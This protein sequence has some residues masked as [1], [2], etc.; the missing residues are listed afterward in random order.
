M[1]HARFS[2]LHR[3]FKTGQMS[4]RA[5]LSMSAALGAFALTARP[6]TGHAQ[7]VGGELRIGAEFKHIAEDIHAPETTDA[8]SVLGQS[9]ESLAT[10]D[11]ENIVRPRVAESWQATDDLTEWTLHL[12]RNVTWHN[13]DPLTASDVIW[14]MNRAGMEGRAFRGVLDLAEEPEKIDDFTVKLRLNSPALYVPYALTERFLLLVHP[15]YKGGLEGIGT[16]PFVPQEILSD[17]VTLDAFE[18]YR[19]GRPNLDRIEFR[20][21][22]DPETRTAAF[23]ADEIQISTTEPNWEAVQEGYAVWAPTSVTRVARMRVDQTPYDN[24]NVRR[25]LRLAV[26]IAAFNDKTGGGESCGNTPRGQ[27]THKCGN[28]DCSVACCK[29]V[30]TN[31]HISPIH[32]EFRDAGAMPY[33]REESRRLLADSNVEP[34]RIYEI[35]CR[36]RD[37]SFA[38]VLSSA[39]DEVGFKAEPKVMEDSAFWNGWMQHSFSVTPWSHRPTATQIYQLAYVS[40]APFN[41]SGYS[42]P[43]LDSIIESVASSWEGQRDRMERAAQIM[44]EDGPII[45]PSFERT[46]VGVQDKVQGVEIDAYKTLDLRSAWIEQ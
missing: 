32:P 43:E 29:D 40:G 7:A 28:G 19:G 13:G 8:L 39:L 12:D 3:H 16:G 45:Q 20:E 9:F 33:D 2:D 31:D 37:E 11:V 14:N 17:R 26:D 18:G 30:A 42:N 46:A 1:M 36:A 5:F 6:R 4:R 10:T 25:A 15:N 24:P 38:R 35:T 21:I 27:K 22:A 41:E 44:H 34:D 23:R